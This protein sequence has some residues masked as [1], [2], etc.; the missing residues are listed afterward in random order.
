M[1]TKDLKTGQIFFHPDVGLQ[2]MAV[3]CDYNEDYMILAV[4]SDVLVPF[5][6]LEGMRVG[7]I[8][9]LNSNQYPTI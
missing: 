5:V 7:C 2:C 9:A 8:D 1:K 4:G 6:W 3:E